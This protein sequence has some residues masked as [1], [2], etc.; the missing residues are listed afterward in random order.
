MVVHSAKCI[1][2]LSQT[3]LY[4]PIMYTA[5]VGNLDETDVYTQDSRL[6]LADGK[7]LTYLTTRC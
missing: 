3:I 4:D 6:L 1:F 7:E 2:S 5:N